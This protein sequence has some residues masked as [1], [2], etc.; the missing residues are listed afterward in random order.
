MRTWDI[1][2]WG[3]WLGVWG[4]LIKAEKRGCLL[5]E[6]EYGTSPESGEV[7]QAKA[8]PLQED[9]DSGVTIHQVLP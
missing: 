5:G 9:L 8:L 4:Q 7:P 1:R 2:T 3:F 6:I